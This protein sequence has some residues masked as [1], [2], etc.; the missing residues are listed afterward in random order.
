MP[1]MIGVDLAREIRS[2]QDQ[3][4]VDKQL[5]LVLI[6]GDNLFSEHIRREMYLFDDMLQKP[7]TI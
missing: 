5:K 2:L 6:S 7:F 1:H 4:K 3:E